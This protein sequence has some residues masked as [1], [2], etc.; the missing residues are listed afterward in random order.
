MKSEQ[1]QASQEI[2]LSHLIAILWRYKASIILF[3]V[4]CSSLTVFYAINKPDIYTVNGLYSPK[5]IDGGSSL[6]KLA[7]Q[8]GGLASMAGINLGG[9]SGDKTDMALEVLRSRAFLQ[10]FIEKHDLTAHLMAVKKWDKAS[11]QLIYDETLFNVETQ[12]W[13]REVPAN[14]SKIPTSYEAFP[15]LEKN[16]SIE[17]ISK[18]GIV[19][20]Q[21]N[22]YSPKIAAQWLNLMVADLNNFWQ[23]KELKQSKKLIE[24]LTKNAFE[25]SQSELK[26]VLYSLV[27]E[28]TK[29]Y[30]LAQIEEESVLESVVGIIIPE[31]KSAP[32]R[33]LLCIIGTIFS[34]FLASIIALIVGISRDR[35]RCRDSL[36]LA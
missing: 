7:G 11:N 5:S 15:F 35:K 2:K 25:A 10:S 22:Y 14:K 28:Q 13:I 27:A 16:L 29:S 31:Q 24:V 19:K 8:F 34:G 1:S 23:Q 12:Q 30:V 17:Y 21:L 26:S 3:T 18:K 9:G 36:E 6:S 33:T 4:T 32:S 20:I